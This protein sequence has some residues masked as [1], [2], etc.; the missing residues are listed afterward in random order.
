MSRSL[1]SML[2]RRFGTRV[3]AEERRAFLRASL[4]VSA[5]LMLS[6]GTALARQPRQG[7]KRVVVVGAGFAGLSCAFE[8]KSAGYDVTI[9]EARGR[10]GGR[11]LSFGDYVAGATVEGGGELIGSNH[12]NWVGYA[13]RFGL[14]FTDVSDYELEY[15]VIIDGKR[16]SADDALKLWE[17]MESAA[18]ALNELAKDLDADEP[19]K[20]PT[21][22]DH[23]ARSIDAWIESLDVDA[24]VKRGLRIQFMADNGQDPTK[25]SLLGNLAMIKGGQLEKFWTE[26][27]VYRCAGGNQQLAT[28]LAE[29]IGGE[30]IITGLSVRSIRVEEKR[31]SVECRDGRTIECDDV[32]L[33]APPSVWHKLEVTPALPEALRPQMGSNVK[34]LARLKSRFWVEK[35]LAPDALTSGD[36]SMTWDGTDAQPE[37]KEALMV[38]FSGGAASENC[39][40]QKGAEADRAYAE[41]LEAIYP[42]YRE[43]FLDA[44]FMDWPGDTWS[45]A[46]YSFPA[47]GEVTKVGPLLRAGRSRLHFAGEHCSYA[48]I[49][50]MEGALHSGVSLAK[51]LARRD[52]VAGG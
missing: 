5:G 44:R 36:V 34:Y 31:V 4:A 10:V 33:T 50:Y 29:G 23:D 12:P 14:S 39:R 18:Q 24:L 7:A 11:V 52:G 43:A 21:A 22:K 20:H 49:G 19:W 15:P 17:D 42:G 9:V 46:S 48:F 38:A 16:L 1:Y 28:K 3:S 41:R 40:K 45:G 25:Q 27:E 35:G 8:L 6:G 2:Q 13:E 37:A 32:V 47:P 51:R 26:S 30:R